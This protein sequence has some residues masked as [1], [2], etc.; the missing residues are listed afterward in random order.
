MTSL[1]DDW[2]GRLAP[3]PPKRPAP[4]A[5][6]AGRNLPQ[7]IAT[8]VILLAIV[9]ASLFLWSEGFLFLVIAFL[10]VG[11]WEA[12]GAFSAR[13]VY[14]PLAPLW[15]G[16]IAM[17][18]STWLW[19]DAGLLISFFIASLAVVALRV[20]RADMWARRDAA[21]AMFAL[22]WIGLLGGFSLLLAQLPNGPWAVVTFVVLPVANDTGG[23][24]AGI[25]AGRHPIAPTISPKKSWEGFAG[26]VVLAT[27]VG[28]VCSHFALDIDFWWGFVLGIACAIG[29]TCGDLA[30]SLLKRDLGVK[31]MG[32]IFPGHGG[33]L[34]RVDSILVC[35][36]IVYLILL[37]AM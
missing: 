22:A 4:S 30:E 6:K 17:A 21:A 16:S 32:S 25:L 7:A 31:D 15:I 19:E 3:H 28:V 27:A 11:L 29:A 24:F 1:N 18:V 2:M 14:I 10:V 13:Q 26:S 9:W 23:Y 34:D 8:A 33:V 12:A 35:A 5:S 20:R 37:L 36:P